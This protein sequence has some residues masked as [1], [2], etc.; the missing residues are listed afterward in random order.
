MDIKKY[1]I[2]YNLPSSLVELKHKEGV[3][4]AC[5]CGLMQN[6]RDQGLVQYEKTGN[7]V[8][9]SLTAMGDVVMSLLTEV[10]R[11]MEHFE[12]TKI[13]E[14]TVTDDNFLLSVIQSMKNKI[15]FGKNIAK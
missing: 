11:Q 14:P 9:I 12:H 15:C 5:V 2:L 7:K 4:Y 3:T 10:Y 1:K 8:I 13:P 6:F